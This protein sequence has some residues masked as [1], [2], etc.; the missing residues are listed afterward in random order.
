MTQTLDRIG[1]M[2][3][4][5][6]PQSDALVKA[7]SQRG[8]AEVQAA[9]LIAQRFP[10]NEAAA[11]DQ[12]LV[13][14]QRPGLAEGAVYEY[15][16]GGTAIS[17]P[18]IRL[19]EAIAQ[20]WGNLQFGFQVIEQRVGMSTVEAF[21]WD[22]ESNTRQTRTFQV[23]HTRHTKKGQYALEDPRDIYETE[24]NNGARR[25]R[26]CIL[27][28]IPGDIIEDAV[29]ECEKTL[30][31]KADLSPDGVKKMLDTF[32]KVGVT[33]EQ[34]EGR[35]QRKINAI[36]AAQMIGLH[37]IYTSIKDGM[38]TAA[39]WFEVEGEEAGTSEAR[40]GNARVKEALR[41]KAATPSPDAS[42][43]AAQAEEPASPAD[44]PTPD[45]NAPQAGAGDV[46]AQAR[47][48]ALLRLKRG[49]KT[50]NQV[51]IDARK[52]FADHE[53]ADPPADYEQ[54]K[55]LPL[56]VLNAILEAM[57]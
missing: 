21:A 24:A 46:E 56:D 51:L 18:S 4:G 42:P 29:A 22:L 23:P 1:E 7:T 10:R 30:K 20:K 44:T 13:A 53:M 8:I 5:A 34:I 57:K 28:L 26:A 31:A 9:M 16:R 50:E 25:L 17:G 45:P 55:A 12:I 33:K 3:I 6:Q 38:S 35:I 48:D 41:G 15:A 47:R 54:V 14:C 43:E 36:T 19:A 49:G 52:F 27:G 39:E 11:R 2:P 40:G 32:A 37:R